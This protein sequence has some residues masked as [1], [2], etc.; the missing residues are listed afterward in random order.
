MVVPCLRPDC[1]GFHV[2]VPKGLEARARVAEVTSGTKGRKAPRP[3]ESF[4]RLIRLAAIER[5][6]GHCLRCGDDRCLDVHHRRIKGMGGDPRPHTDCLCN[7]A[8]LC[9]FACHLGWAHRERT[10]AEAEGFVVPNSTL[11]PGSVSVMVHGAGG[12]GSALFPTCTGMWVS[13]APKG[14]AA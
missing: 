9:H 11:L 10:E 6:G 14:V 3:A 8:T 1:L 2:A 4:P 13:N 7:A 12:G 5:D